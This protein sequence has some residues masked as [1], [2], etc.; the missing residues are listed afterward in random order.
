MKPLTMFLPG[1][2]Q[3]AA[4]RFDRAAVAT[5]QAAHII[6]CDTNLDPNVLTV[7]IFVN[8]DHV[9]RADERFH[10]HFNS[11]SHSGVRPELPS[12]DYS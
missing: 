8:L 12:P 4:D 1:E 11:I 6:R 10:D 2:E 7:A 9:G 3:D 5:D